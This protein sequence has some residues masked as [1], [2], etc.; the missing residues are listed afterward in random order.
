ME[1][2]FNRKVKEH[3]GDL[4]SANIEND[5]RYLKFM[6]AVYLINRSKDFSIARNEEDEELEMTQATVDIHCPYTKEVMVHPVKCKKCNH[7]YEKVNVEQLLLKKRVI[8]CPVVGC[9]V[10]DMVLADLEP[11]LDME[12][13][14]KQAQRNAKKNR[15]EKT[16]NAIELEC[17]D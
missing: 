7:V 9:K 13:T 6:K 4:S 10:K 1:G 3:T 14:I 5:E 12:V 2:V 17:D 15:Q 16:S 8:Q 11:D